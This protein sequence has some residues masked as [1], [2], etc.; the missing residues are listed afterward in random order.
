MAAILENPRLP[1]SEVKSS[2]PPH[3]KLSL[4]VFTST[5]EDLRLSLQSAQFF[6]YN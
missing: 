1:P 3:L 5:P 4:T 2:L 6:Y